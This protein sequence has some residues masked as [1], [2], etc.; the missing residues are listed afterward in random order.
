MYF[1]SD[2]VCI[3]GNNGEADLRGM[4]EA[5]ARTPVVGVGSAPVLGLPFVV[6]VGTGGTCIGSGAITPLPF[7]VWSV[8]LNSSTDQTGV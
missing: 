6:I 2:G 7:T 1:G 5:G 8:Q 3:G 4:S